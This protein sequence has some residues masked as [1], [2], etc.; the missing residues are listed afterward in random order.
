MYTF[1]YRTHFTSEKTELKTE[2]HINGQGHDPS[3]ASALSPLHLLEAESKIALHYDIYI[4]ILYI[5][6]LNSKNMTYIC[7]RAKPNFFSRNI[8]LT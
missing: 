8:F 5:N 6:M 7:Y 4:L 1:I 2:D 3:K